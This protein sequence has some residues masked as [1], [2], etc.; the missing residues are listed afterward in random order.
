AADLANQL[1]ALGI[2]AMIEGV[3]WDTAYDRALS[4]PLI[5]GWG[6]HTPMEL[7][8]IYHTDGDTG[9]ALYSPYANPTVDAYMDAALASTDLETSYDLW[10][11][12][13]WDGQTGVTQEGDIPWI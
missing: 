11:K 3:G 7:Y 2:D 1:G 9:S 6:A 4:D 10:R 13:Q 12:A 5:W 8:N